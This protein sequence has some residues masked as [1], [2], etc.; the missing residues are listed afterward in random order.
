MN[1]VQGNFQNKKKMCSDREDDYNKYV[2]KMKKLYTRGREG[3]K[4]DEDVF[5]E[6]CKFIDSEKKFRNELIGL[7]K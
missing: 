3:K 7:G 1:R 4:Q 5:V 2:S 6:T